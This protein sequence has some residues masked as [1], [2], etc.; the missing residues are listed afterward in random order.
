M[1]TCQTN[2]RTQSATQ[3]PSKPAAGAHIRNAREGFDVGWEFASYGLTQPDHAESDV[4]SGFRAAADHFGTQTLKCDRF[5]R[6]Y[7]QLR[8]NAWRRNRI[9]DD[10]VTP[11]Y[12]AKIVPVHCPI[13]RKPL[14]V[15]T[16]LGTDWS[17]DRII[18]DGGYAPGNLVVM[19]SHANMAKDSMSYRQILRTVAKGQSAHGLSHLEWA[20]LAA[21][22][23]MVADQDSILPLIALPPAGMMIRNRYTALQV[24]TMHLIFE[25]KKSRA[26]AA[27]RA[28]CPGKTAKRAMEG[29][30]DTAAALVASKTRCAGDRIQAV[31][32]M[33]DA[34]LD[35]TLM[36]LFRAWLD[37]MP[38]DGPEVCTQTLRRH[39]GVVRP[40]AKDMVSHWGL[41][42]RGYAASEA[43]T[44]H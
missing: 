32:A 14:T 17:I 10:G 1:N 4:L 18:N 44:L 6:K 11:E 3:H 20:R 34:W 24:M 5:V 19:S 33:G 8:L 38:A 37:E 31:W 22:V 27:L 41:E 40:A 42:S 26:R 35:G 13:T 16:G 25:G 7:L 36:R 2:E 39:V 43:D 30:L 23:G 15:A 9:F 28:V 29:Y 21:V 12:L